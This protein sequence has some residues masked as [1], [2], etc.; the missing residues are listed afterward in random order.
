MYW[1]N[2]SLLQAF[3]LDLSF[4]LLVPVYTVFFNGCYDKFFSVA[5]LQAN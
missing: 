1:M 4:L 2:Y 3:T 5:A